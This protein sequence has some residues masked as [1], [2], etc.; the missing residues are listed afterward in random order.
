M[1][2]KE[3]VL[4]NKFTLIDVYKE[5]FEAAY[6][7]A[8]KVFSVLL[9]CFITIFKVISVLLLLAFLTQIIAFFFSIVFI[10][11]YRETVS[12]PLD[13]HSITVLSNEDLMGV[14]FIW[15]VLFCAMFYLYIVGVL[16]RLHITLMK[17]VEHIYLFFLKSTTRKLPLT[18]DEMKE[19]GIATLYDWHLWLSKNYTRKLKYLGIVTIKIPKVI[20]KQIAQETGYY[21]QFY[22]SYCSVEELLQIGPTIVY[23]YYNDDKPII[24]GFDFKAAYER[25]N[26]V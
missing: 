1:T 19:L 6:K 3:V 14:A 21:I 25:I 8:K 13:F 11:A 15:G 5:N 23:T 4:E 2:R 18:K 16:Q 7:L 22:D 26:I 20:A 17:G 10:D 9:E 12:T 24:K